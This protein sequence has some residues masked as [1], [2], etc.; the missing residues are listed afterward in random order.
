M[1]NS[2]IIEFELP[3][4]KGVLGI[5]VESCRGLIDSPLVSE[6]KLSFRRWV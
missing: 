4:A 3:V 1:P 2:D 5:V 6:F